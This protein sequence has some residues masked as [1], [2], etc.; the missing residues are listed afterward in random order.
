[1]TAATASSTRRARKYVTAVG[2]TTLVRSAHQH[3]GWTETAWCGAG[4][5]CSAINGQRRLAGRH[6]RLHPARRRR[7]VR[8]RR[9][10]DRR[11]RLRLHRLPGALGLAAS[12]AAPASS[13]P[14]IASVYAL[15]GNAS[16]VERLLPLRPHRVAVRCERRQQRELLPGQVVHRRCRVGRAHRARHAERHRSLLTHRPEPG[17]RFS[18]CRHPGSALSGAQTGAPL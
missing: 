5:G 11:R 17:W 13:A 2:G 12:S 4:S 15:A 18:G 14:I 1:M 8:R 10:R 16:S 7:R 3:R 6:H 9:P